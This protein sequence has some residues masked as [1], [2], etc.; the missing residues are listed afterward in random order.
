MLVCVSGKVQL[1]RL[2]QF[3]HVHWHQHIT[4]DFHEQ[5][6]ISLLFSCYIVMLWIWC[7]LLY[8]LGWMMRLWMDRL[9][10]GRAGGSSVSVILTAALYCR[11]SGIIS[12]C[13]QNLCL[14]MTCEC[15]QYLRLSICYLRLIRYSP[16][17][18]FFTRLKKK[19][20]LA[21][22]G[23]VSCRAC[24]LCVTVNLMSRETTSSFCRSS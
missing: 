23:V 4:Y 3:L 10:R 13:L 12:A 16:P 7:R 20:E 2:S 6:E 9:W 24:G 18:S 15:L 11:S 22:S 8:V 21:V 1:Y 19:T 5:K 17:C 14:F